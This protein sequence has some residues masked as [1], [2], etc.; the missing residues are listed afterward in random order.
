MNPDPAD[1][2]ASPV[3]LPLSKASTAAFLAGFACMAAELT[4]VRVLAPHFGDSA[5]VWTNVIGVILFAL[6]AGAFLGGQLAG[7]AKADL[8]PMRLLFGGGVLLALVPFVSGAVGGVLLPGDLPLDAALPAL[9]RGSL[10]ASAA[11]FVPPMLLLGAVAPLLVALLAGGRVAVG[12]AAGLVSAAG[13]IGSLCGTFAATHWL[14]PGFGC[15]ATLLIAA[16][17]ILLAGAVL[18]PRIGKRAHLLV[19][20]V[21]AIGGARLLPEPMRA[22]LEGQQLLAEVE[23][24]YQ[25]LQVLRDIRSEPARILLTINEGLDSYHSVSVEGSSLTGGAYYDYH[26]LAPWLVGDGRAPA[27]L[28]VLSIGDA[29]GS[30]RTVYAG[31]H[32]QA[33]V[34]GVDLDPA[35]LAL[36]DEFFPGPK[37]DGRRFALDG[38]LFLERTHDVWHVIH[39]DAYA[40]QVYVP[41]HLASREFFATARER[42]ADNGILACNVGALQPDDPVLRAIG[43]T[44]AAVFGHA[45]AMQV[46]GTRNFL[47]IARRGLRPDPACL[48]PM[49]PNLSHLSATDAVRFRG[50]LDAAKDPKVWSDVGYGG[51]VLVDDRPQLDE[52]LHHSYVERA[53]VA[54]ALGCRGAVDPQGAELDAYE[55]ASRRNW[56]GVLDAVTSSSAATPYL[57]ELAGDARWSLR[58]L[59]AA[60][61]EYRAALELAGDAAGRQRLQ[62]KLDALAED[63]APTLR[64]E[65]VARRNGWLQAGILISLAA[66]GAVLLRRGRMA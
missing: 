50:V 10:V 6:A 39:V 4:A 36:G 59:H 11:L 62:G 15:R 12:R 34:D 52:L 45:I 21:L 47:L 64:A 53:D 63:T 57:R 14:V 43:S 22:P 25:F 55:A 49:Q 28:R 38:R 60:A 19:L 56:P 46:P 17:A 13:T 30:L 26:V 20:P 27:D 66:L 41:A 54:E 3:S 32:P 23:S 58:Q 51:P 9:V 24:R 16:A 65:A 2:A 1:S 35:T 37:A 18:T 42:L 5:Y 33:R 61:S 29:A 8:W 7:S 31:V 48:A 44:V 40:H